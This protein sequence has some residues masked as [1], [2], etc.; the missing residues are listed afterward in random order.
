MLDD[1]LI[2]SVGQ[3]LERSRNLQGAISKPFPREFHT[4]AQTCRQSVNIVIRGLEALLKDA[5]YRARGAESI[6]LRDYKRRVKDLDLLENVAFAALMRVN[7]DDHLMTKL[8]GDI[9]KEINYPLVP[10]VVSCQSQYYFQAYPLFGLMSVPQKEVNHLLHLPDLYHELGHFVL[11]EENNP[12]VAPFI[13]SYERSIA[14]ALT[15]FH[16]L[17]RKPTRGPRMDAEVIPVWEDCWLNA[18]AMEFYC[19]LFGTCACG[20]AYGWAHLHLCSK[21]GQHP[22]VV[23]RTRG[24]SHPPDEARMFVILEA[25]AAMGYR[26]EASLIEKQWRELLWVGGFATNADYPRCFPSQVLKEVANHAVNGYRDMGCHSAP[27]QKNCA[28]HSALNRAWDE[29]WK[30][31]KD[32]AEWER[33]QVRQLF[34]S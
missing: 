7:D 27:I 19:D 26:S 16:K 6:R 24:S 5:R 12:V 33:Q 22:F 23:E 10:P 20:P 3:L 21:R 13:Q 30:S 32:F 15:H 4:L 34:E 9:A 29:F 2:A 25:L 14:S 31:P 18:W 17:R 11:L 1:Y 28:V 8:V